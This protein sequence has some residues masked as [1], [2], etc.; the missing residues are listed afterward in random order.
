MWAPISN[1]RADNHGQ[2]EGGRQMA[3][4]ANHR[5]GESRRRMMMTYSRLDKKRHKDAVER[6][7]ELDFFSRAQES[8]NSPFR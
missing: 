8:R 1:F 2:M 3:L 5:R 4:A 7:L 6:N